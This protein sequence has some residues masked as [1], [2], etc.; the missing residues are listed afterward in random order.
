MF[1]LCRLL[2]RRRRRTTRELDAWLVESL[3]SRTLLTATHINE[4]FVNPPGTDTGNEYHRTPG[5]PSTTVAANTCLVAIEGDSTGAGTIDKV[6]P[7]SGLSIGSNG[8]L[9]LRAGNTYTVDPNSGVATAMG[10]G[11]ETISTVSNDIE[12][13]SNTLLLIVG[14]SSTAGGDVDS[15]NNG[16]RWRGDRL[17]DH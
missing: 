8:F 11:W 7:L 4:V 2:P 16:T 15:A 6:F 1:G 14:D 13:G 9:V 17:D 10:T 5:T 12:N 3:E